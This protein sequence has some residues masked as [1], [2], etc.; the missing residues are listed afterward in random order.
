MVIH[1]TAVLR[2]MRATY[3]Y[4]TKQSLAFGTDRFQNDTLQALHCLISQEIKGRKV[5]QRPQWNQ[6]EKSQYIAGFS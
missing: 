3:G 5:K 2:L 1:E 4:L 6:N